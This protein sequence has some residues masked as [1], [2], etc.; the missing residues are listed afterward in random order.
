MIMLSFETT[1]EVVLHLTTNHLKGNFTLWYPYALFQNS[2]TEKQTGFAAKDSVFEHP[3][4]TLFI[5]CTVIIIATLFVAHMLVKKKLKKQ[6]ILTN[7]ETEIR[8]AKRVHDEIANEIYNVMCH[9][10]SNDLGEV[11]NKERLL[12]NLE[13]VYNKSRNISRE[14]NN[15]DTGRGY[16]SQLKL[17][18]SEYQ[19]AD[20]NIIIKDVDKIDWNK[21]SETKKIAVYRALQEIMVNMKKHSNATLV[22]INFKLKR[23]KI[24]IS[25]SD[26]GIGM[27]ISP[28]TSK[29]G[30]LNVENRMVS[31]NGKV[32]F[33][34]KPGKGLHLTLT[35][36]A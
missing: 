27:Q 4:A 18:L 36:P 33:E 31:I 34:P 2:I 20:V 23:G 12:I 19:A 22:V 25:Y 17:M 3:E 14:I 6:K 7:Y 32:I 9:A 24:C 10:S 15:I 35:Y 1:R 16:K 26:N 30:L 29:N 11:N 13:T 8:I 21:I 5:I 28:I